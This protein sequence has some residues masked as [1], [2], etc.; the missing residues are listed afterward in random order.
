MLHTTEEA[1]RDHFNRAI[2]AC[3]AVERVKK[4]RDYAFVHFRDRIQANT[5][6]R[7]LDG[8]VFEGS[9]IEVTWAKPVDKNDS[10]RI[11]RTNSSTVNN[12]LSRLQC[13]LS[14]QV[15]PSTLIQPVGITNFTN[16]NLM[17]ITS[18]KAKLK[19]PVSNC[20]DSS[21]LKLFNSG[22]SAN[23]IPQMS[24]LSV[25]FKSAE[26]QPLGKTGNI[27]GTMNG[28]QLKNICLGKGF[29]LP[30]IVVH[31]HEPGSHLTGEQN[32]L[33]TAQVLIPG[34]HRQFVS[35]LVFV[36]P[37]EA[38]K[39]VAGATSQWL[40]SQCCIIR[41]TIEELSLGSVSSVQSTNCKVPELFKNPWDVSHPLLAS[42]ITSEDAQN[43]PQ[44]N[45]LGKSSSITKWTHKMSTQYTTLDPASPSEGRQTSICNTQSLTDLVARG[46]G[47]RDIV[48]PQGDPAAW[49][50]QS[51]TLSLDPGPEML[52]LAT[53]ASTRY[54][55]QESLN[56]MQW[57]DGTSISIDAYAHPQVCVGC[58]GDVGR[59]IDDENLIKEK[60]GRCYC[61]K[62][63]LDDLDSG[64]VPLSLQAESSL[65]YDEEVDKV[66]T[67]LGARVP[68]EQANENLAPH[69]D[70]TVTVK[71]ISP[72]PLSSNGEKEFG[73]LTN[74]LR[75]PGRNVSINNASN[76]NYQSFRQT[77]NALS[78]EQ[79][80]SRLSNLGKPVLEHTYSQQGLSD[81]FARMYVKL[82]NQDFK[83]NRSTES[84]RMSGGRCHLCLQSSSE[85]H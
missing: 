82:D 47:Q 67:P 84:K 15:L 58:N 30:K 62:A 6:L 7:Q 11:S 26:F 27:S 79:M 28:T 55:L 13:G 53:Q 69:K 34:L 33:Y 70:T 4:I 41:P 12:L 75:C 40:L 24:P 22:S 46:E 20:H 32:T 18:S 52:G 71:H 45:S 37:E 21:A 3:D 57:R 36:S 5:A 10:V 61:L 81:S 77:N 78:L 8:T 65:R 50:V 31:A 51:C 2:G 9:Q 35:P 39:H 54:R 48:H 60:L 64:K 83:S 42:T 38:M 23:L 74:E 49:K 76:F 59:M 29:G 56:D 25:G 17:D 19:T 44:Y 68:L 85:I 1:L 80:V 73:L 63:T 72:G 14:N 16:L 43:L 66:L